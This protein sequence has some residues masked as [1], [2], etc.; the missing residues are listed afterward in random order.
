M[1]GRG[2][3]T[4]VRG[5]GADARITGGMSLLFEDQPCDRRSMAQ[6]TLITLTDDIDGSEASE[7]VVF[8]LDGAT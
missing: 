5:R 1:P 2:S 8:G 3:G 7:T 4:G 6:R